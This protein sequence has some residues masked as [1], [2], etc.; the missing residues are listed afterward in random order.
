VCTRAGRR[1]WFNLPHRP[2]RFPGVWTYGWRREGEKTVEECVS[3]MG[4]DTWIKL[5]IWTGEGVGVYSTVTWGLLWDWLWLELLYSFHC[6]FP[7]LILSS[8]LSF[9]LLSLIMFPLPHSSSPSS[10]K[11]YGGVGGVAYV[12]AE[13]ASTK[14]LSN[15]L[16]RHLPVAGQ[17]QEKNLFL[18]FLC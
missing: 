8:P 15:A 18:F 2:L 13:A 10:T 17:V 6:S 12:R 16:G 9:P 4:K 1:H 11:L 7:P 3:S 5:N 14:K